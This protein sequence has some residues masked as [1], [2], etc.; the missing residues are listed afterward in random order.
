LSFALWTPA[1]RKSD[2]D[3]RDRLANSNDG[4]VSDT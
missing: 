2:A 4:S 1:W 3:Q